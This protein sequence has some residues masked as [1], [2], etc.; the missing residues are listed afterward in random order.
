VKRRSFGVIVALLAV[1]VASATAVAHERFRVI[2]TL[3]EVLSTRIEVKDKNGKLTSIRI[4]K[5][6]ALTRDEKKLDISELKA[7]MSVVVDALGDSEADLT[8]TSV[9]VVPAIAGSKKPAEPGKPR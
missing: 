2:G 4:N 6:T 9:R 5:L 3:T 1:C 7:G 8:A